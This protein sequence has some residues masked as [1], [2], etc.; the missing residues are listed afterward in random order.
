MRY[1]Q[2]ETR[3]ERNGSV[4][5]TGY[6]RCNCK[7]E[8]KGHTVELGMENNCIRAD[9]RCFCKVFVHLRCMIMELAIIV[10]SPRLRWRRGSNAAKEGGHTLEIRSSLKK[11]RMKDILYKTC[12]GNCEHELMRWTNCCGVNIGLREVEG[13]Q[14]LDKEPN[15][16]ETWWELKTSIQTPKDLKC[17]FMELS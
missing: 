9:W 17:D 12:N 13:D 2:P 16:N 1:K 3:Y 11:P 5:R 7:N 15:A 8:L 10:T 4:G 6:E 14:F